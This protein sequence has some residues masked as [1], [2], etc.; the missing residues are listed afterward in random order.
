MMNGMV[1]KV[2]AV[3]FAAAMCAAFSAVTA[4]PA[5]AAPAT[6]CPSSCVLSENVK[7]NGERVLVSS[8][9]AEMNALSRAGE[10]SR[11]VRDLSSEFCYDHGYPVYEIRFRTGAGQYR[12]TVDAVTGSVMNIFLQA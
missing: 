6:P 8:S 9:V 2:K 3:M 12:Y 7:P 10:S 11:T 1:K 4:A 5:M